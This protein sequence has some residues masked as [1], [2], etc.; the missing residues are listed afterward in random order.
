MQHPRVSQTP[1]QIAISA[2]STMMTW[3]VEIPGLL[4]LHTAETS[5]HMYGT[6]R[7]FLRHR[8]IVHSAENYYPAPC[9]Q[10]ILQAP[11]TTSAGMSIKGG[12]K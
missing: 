6:W 11:Q 1:G 12:T 2:N 7:E 10:H 8:P 4:S 9:H 3:N 5:M